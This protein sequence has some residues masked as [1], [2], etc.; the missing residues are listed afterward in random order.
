MMR[1]LLLCSPA[2]YHQPHSEWFRNRED[3]LFDFSYA[4]PTEVFSF[5]RHSLVT[6]C[7]RQWGDEVEQINERYYSVLSC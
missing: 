7:C 5:N 3:F 4:F 6:N 1:T 2:I